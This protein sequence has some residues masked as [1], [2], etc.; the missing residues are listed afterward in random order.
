MRMQKRQRSENQKLQ[1][2]QKLQPRHLLSID[3]VFLGVNNLE[4][5]RRAHTNEAAGYG[6]QIS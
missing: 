5:G 6:P 1:L 3:Y 4:I 2:R